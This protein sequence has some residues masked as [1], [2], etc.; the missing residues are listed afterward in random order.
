[1][2][3]AQLPQ[4]YGEVTEIRTS[5]SV[6]APLSIA[7]N[8]LAHV[9]ANA[10][11][12]RLARWWNADTSR[13]LARLR[14][15]KNDP[16]QYP[17]GRNGKGW[18]YADLEAETYDLDLRTPVAQQLEW[19]ERKGAPYLVTAPSN[20]LSLAYAATPEQSKRLAIELIFSTGETVLPN[21][22]QVVAEKLNA[23]M[24]AIYSCE[25]VGTIATQCPAADGYHIVVENAFVEI[26][27]E[28]GFPAAPGEVGKVVVTGFYNYAMPFIRYA[29]GDVAIISDSPCKCGRSL[30]VLAQVVGRTRCAFVF[31]DGTRV[32]PRGSDALAMRSYVPHREFQMVQL[33]RRRIEFRYVPEAAGQ[34]PDLEGLNA[35]IRRRLHATVEIAAIP[36]EAIPRGMGGKIE[37]FVSLVAD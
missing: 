17:E 7:T 18:S 34:L 31:E 19:L 24:A 16:P 9:A 37:S 2:R 29:I 10:A 12:T 6:G 25:E 35:F 1:M 20:A 33:D 8:R 14:F 23:R 13:Q 11:M 26:L 30:P 28:D 32:W 27:R 3:P 4:S 36:M 15:Y 22:R 5:G 21:A